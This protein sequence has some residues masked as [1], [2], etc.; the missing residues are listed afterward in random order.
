M[1]LAKTPYPGSP[2]A[3]S[4]RQGAEIGKRGLLCVKRRQAADPPKSTRVRSFPKADMYSA[5]SLCP[6][7]AISGHR[8]SRSMIAMSVS[9][10]LKPKAYKPWQT[11]CEL[12]L[13]NGHAW[14]PFNIRAAVALCS[15]PEIRCNRGRWGARKSH[16]PTGAGRRNCRT[17]TSR[18]PPDRNGVP[19]AAR[20]YT[21][22]LE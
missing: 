2:E 14:L 4:K 10:A 7:C 15:S 3:T 19:P 9:G 8:K 5:N 13:R 6:L 20:P 1:T 18:D 21:R 16:R 11:R 12:T 22:R 17:G